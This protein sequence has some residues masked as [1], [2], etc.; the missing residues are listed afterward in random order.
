[1]SVD[2]EGIDDNGIGTLTLEAERERH[3]EIGKRTA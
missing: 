2:L 3:Q 1:M